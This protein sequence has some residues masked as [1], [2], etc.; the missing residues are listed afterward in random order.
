MPHHERQ[1]F[2]LCG[3][4]ALN[5]LV[6]TDFG[7]PFVQADLDAVCSVLDP[8]RHAFGVVP[9]P[10]AHRSWTGLG[11][12]D[13]NVLLSALAGRGLEVT[14]H[15]ARRPAEALDL[16][17]GSADGGGRVVGLLIN[18]PTSALA[19]LL[20]AW[21]GTVL[22]SGKHWYAVRRVGSGEWWDCN[23]TRAEAAHV[24]SGDAAARA[25]AAAA[26]LQHGEV[27]VVRARNAT[28]GS[29]GGGGTG[30]GGGSGS[31]ISGSGGGGGAA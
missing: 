20:P 27:L 6:G 10:N 31:G 22:P 15:D 23:S 8:P 14:W 18:Q 24:G 11:D 4:H 1:R 3:L 25:A 2:M 9:L 28:A 29:S 13:V 19:A 21:L 5:A 17:D 26:L 16:R 12:Y 7:P 30:S